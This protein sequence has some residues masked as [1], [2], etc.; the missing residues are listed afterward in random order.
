[1]SYEKGQT[2]REIIK[3]NPALVSLN[4]LITPVHF[5]AQNFFSLLTLSNLI[6]SSGD[7]VFQSSSRNVTKDNK[8]RLGSLYSLSAVCPFGFARTLNDR[9]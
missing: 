5:S 4:I 8:V 7:I 1:M 6:L 3:V 2:A 9:C